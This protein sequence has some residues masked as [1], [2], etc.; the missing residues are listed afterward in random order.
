MRVTWEDRLLELGWEYVVEYSTT[1]SSDPYCP[2]DALVTVK[3][4]GLF[5]GE[6]TT[7]YHL[8]CEHEFGG[9]GWRTN[10]IQVRRCTKCGMEELLQV[11]DPYVASGPFGCTYAEAMCQRARFSA[12]VFR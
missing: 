5:S 11:G 8:T 9:W 1:N 7:T 6:I 4:A 10:E 2:Y 3:G 12:M